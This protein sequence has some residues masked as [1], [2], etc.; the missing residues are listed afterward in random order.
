MKFKLIFSSF[1]TLGL[2]ISFVLFI[3]LMIGYF[4]DLYN[5]QIL[6]LLTMIINFL[7]WLIS[8]LMMDKV[9]R[10]SYDIKEPGFNLFKKRHEELGSFIESICNKHNV[11]KPLIRI[12]RDNNPTAF[13][14]G[15][16]ANNARV[17]FSEGL[18][19]YLNIEE[20]KA[21]LAHEMGHVINRDFIIMTV[22]QTLVQILYEIFYFL[23]RS[24]TNKDR[25][26]SDD[27]D[28]GAGVALI[29]VIAVISY[30]LWWIGTH[31]ILYLSRTR[32]YLADK[33]SFQETENPDALSDALIKI[34]YGIAKEEEDEEVK[35]LLQATRSIGIFDFE[36][37]HGLGR[38]FE[39][40]K[41]TEQ[42]DIDN[43]LNMFLFD[44]FSPWAFYAEI[45]S[46]HPL[47][48]KRIKKLSESAKAAGISS[49]YDWEEVKRRGE[50]LDRKKL[51]KG[52]FS[53]M[54]INFLPYIGL[55]IGV[56]PVL[57]EGTQYL[58]QTFLVLGIAMLIKGLY[59]FSRKKEEPEKTDV[60][61]LM[62]DPYLNPIKGKYVQL[63]G[64]V[65]GKGDSG[66][67]LDENLQMQDDSGSLVYL[68]YNSFIPV[69]GDIYFALKTS[70]RLIGNSVT[71]VGW[72]RRGAYTV[73]DIDF[74]KGQFLMVKSYTRFWRL[75]IGAICLLV[76]LIL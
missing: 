21:V 16:Y 61:T 56:I 2:L 38:S 37:A 24:A 29:L 31:L 17:V 20:Q 60:Y 72:F 35:H 15:S 53:G 34:A 4:F 19:K 27:D 44:I 69:L 48:G 74:I 58:S 7:S 43:I 52:F 67:H 18:F 11:D 50:Q 57:L 12:I 64:K 55:L 9:Q 26:I 3:L 63:E 47:V 76:G 40:I 25:S 59:S 36:S 14:Y 46:S 8:P 49:K 32:E 33:F 28:K 22:A 13:C 66:S 75:I 71:S 68:N 65:I 73:L 70:K 5:I 45:K 10:V 41:D 51:Y 39:Q 23:I 54:I 62:Q 30:I 6:I 1:L 42:E